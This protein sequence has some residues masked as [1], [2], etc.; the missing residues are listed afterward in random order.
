MKEISICIPTF[1]RRIFIEQALSP[2]LQ[3][4]T[5]HKLEQHFEI[6]IFN[7]NGHDETDAYIRSL[8]RKY[9]F[10]VYI[11]QKKRI[12]LRK[13]IEYVPEMATGKYIWFFSDDD[14]PA[15]GSLRYA[16]KLLQQ[17]QPGIVFGNVDDFDG[18]KV[19]SPNMLRMD[20]DKELSTRKEFFRFLSTK[21]GR[22]TYFTSYISNFIIR[23]ELYEKYAGINA[24]YDTDLNM[25]PL[26]TPFLYTDMECPIIITR[27][28][29]V[30]R[31]TDNESWVDPDPV[32]HTVRAY[33]I[34][35]FHFGTIQWLNM[36]DIPLILHLY[37][38]FHVLERTSISLFIQIP[39]GIQLIRF[40]WRL[41][42]KIYSVVFPK[43]KDAETSS[44]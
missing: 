42:K 34:S 10:I 31:R 4:I 24:K 30:L 29:I 3:E 7:D 9:P 19:T 44:A 38:I 11:M 15:E 36:W 28:P 5:K 41:E 43:E 25:T 22:I 8:V 20:C 32:A 40:Y 39:F 6:V 16:L 37:F 13:A 21:F 12:G 33:K 14:V 27:K 18:K 35:G 26:I 17:K 23:R 2:M 1:K